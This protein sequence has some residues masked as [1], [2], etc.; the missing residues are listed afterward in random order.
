MSAILAASLRSHGG[1]LRIP[2]FI[3]VYNEG[4]SS[5]SMSDVRAGDILIYEGY[6]ANNV[7]TTTPTGFT[8]IASGQTSNFSYRY[9]Y[10]VATGGET[11]VSTLLNVTVVQYRGCAVGAMNTFN[12]TTSAGTGNIPFLSS[13]Q[14][15]SG[16][17]SVVG[18]VATRTAPSGNPSGMTI[19]GFQVWTLENTASFSAHAVTL[20][21]F[22]ETYASLSIEMKPL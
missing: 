13:L 9:A 3:A 11:S 4:G 14:D 1:G 16:G 17:S 6:A 10:K 20:G 8:S 18:M 5:V 7:S 21:S 22:P 15:T 2:T 12:N 19:R